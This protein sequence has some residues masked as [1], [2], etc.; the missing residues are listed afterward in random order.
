MPDIDLLRHLGDQLIPP[1]LDDLRETAR[2]R[3]RRTSTVVVF[4][5]A[6]AVAIVVGALQLSAT[7]H[8]SSPEPAPTPTPDHSSSRPL[9]YAEGR[10][11]HYG[12]QAVTIPGRVVELDLTDDGV[13]VRTADRRIW[14]TD[15]TAVD[16]IGAIGES[17]WGD[18]L[19]DQ[20][21]GRMVSGNSG[22]DVAWFEFPRPQSPEAVVYDTA[23]G[24]VSDPAPLGLD[25]TDVV[26]GLYSVDSDAVYGFTDLTFGEE[27]RP[28][29]R[30]EYATGAFKVIEGQRYEEILR[31]RDLNRTLLVSHD[32]APQPADYV[33][34][35][36]LQQFSVRGSVVRPVGD[37]PL[38]V[39]DGLTGRAFRFSAPP[40]Y[41]DTDPLWLVQWLDDDTVVL[42]AEQ[43]DGVDLL[44]CHV[45]TSECSIALHVS[46]DAVVP[47][48]PDPNSSLKSSD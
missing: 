3:T 2:R 17:A 13:A 30:I 23:S 37:Q 38:S 44:E 25:Y 48:I 20:Y 45:S 28:T 14:F 6:A 8:D 47:E 34:F 41:P 29:W 22:S 15:G 40:G 4:A 39:L 42:H 21:V 31:S 18:V 11:L 36:G 19:W 26:S 46:S 32:K 12:D 1:P 24:Q 35:D 43:R 10:T 5:S 16:E 7:D 33:P 27:L 9:T